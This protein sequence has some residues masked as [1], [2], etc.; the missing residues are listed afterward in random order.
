MENIG[1]GVLAL[2]AEWHNASL[3]IFTAQPP[4]SPGLSITVNRDR[5]PFGTALETYAE[6]QLEKLRHQLKAFELKAKEAFQL[7]GRPA[8]DLEFVWHTDD[9]GPVHQLLVCVA[10]GQ[11]LLNFAASSQGLMN[12][13][14]RAEV[15]RILLS[16]R[17]HPAA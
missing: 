6:D 10:D 5:L 2:P 15:R 1:E 4:G 17:F 13:S 8:C 14:Q 7:D 12:A 16:F 9:A 3:H 11:K